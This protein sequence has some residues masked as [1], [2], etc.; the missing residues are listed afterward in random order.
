V[1]SSSEG[2][3]RPAI[4]VN[5]RELMLGQDRSGRWVI[6]K[7]GDTVRPAEE[8]LLWLLPLL[9][10]SPAEVEEAVTPGGIRGGLLSAL[11]R[12]AL[13]SGSNYWAGLALGWIE[14]GFPVADVLDELL[15][16]RDSVARPQPIRHRAL[17]L[18]RNTR[19]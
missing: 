9:E 2:E 12:F 17:R 7:P 1:D 3:L 19:A 18:W 6:W 13:S 8:Y 10:K 5:N 4:A 16:T 11:V 14:A 15:A